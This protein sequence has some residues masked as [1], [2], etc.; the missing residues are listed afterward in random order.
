MSTQDAALFTEVFGRPLKPRRAPLEAIDAEHADTLC[1]Q[2]WVVIED[3]ITPAHAAMVRAAMLELLG[4]LG[5]NQFEGMRTQRA[6]SLLAKT[7]TLDALVEHPR[8]LALVDAFLENALLSAALVVH[9]G[10]GEV[11]QPWHCDGEFYGVPRPRAPIGVSTVWALDE[12]T[13]DNGATE[14][15]GRSHL[16]G[17]QRPALGQDVATVR[18]IMPAGSVAV[19]FDN[20]HHRAGSNTTARARCGVTIQYCQGWARTI[21]NMALAV[22]RDVVRTLS[23]RL[24]DLVGYSI[25]HAFVGYVDGRHPKKQLGES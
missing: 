1:S 8:V 10:P 11:E 18:A 13:A 24:Q 5:R 17:D 22:P 19:F 14:I 25:H 6:Y 7:R 4:P 21:E 15:V 9:L 16:W 3:A 12:F 2:G 20:L 23:P